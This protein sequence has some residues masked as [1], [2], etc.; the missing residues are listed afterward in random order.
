MSRL[1]WLNNYLYFCREITMKLAIHILLAYLVLTLLFTGALVAAFAIP[2]AAVKDNLQQSVQQVTDDG[3]MF[4]AQVGPVEPFKVGTFSDCLIL[5]IAYCSD[6]DHPLHAAMSDRFLILDGSPE[7]AALQMVEHPE[8]PLLQPVIYSR[9]WHGNQIIIKPL[10]YLTTMHG[11]RAINCVLLAVLLLLLLAVMWRRVGHADALIVTLCLA[12][13]IVPSVPMSLNYVPTFYIALLASLAILCRKAVTANW[14]RAV[15]LFFVI[16]ALTTYF[17][18]L[19][20]PMVALAVPLTVYMLYKKPDNAWRTVIMLSLA[21][22]AGYALLWATKWVLSALITGHAAIEDAM[23]AVTQRTVGYDEQDY[24]MWCLKATTA[25]LTAVVLI[26]TTVIALFGKS[27]QTLRRNSWML[28]VAMASFVWTFVLL[29]HTWRHPHF[30]WRTYV[31]LAI[32]VMLFLWHTLD[33]K[34]PLALFNKTKITSKE[35]SL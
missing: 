1:D 35:P 18:L 29:E 21:W 9:Y 19:T 20:T 12:A 7:D 27:W 23:G 11:I 28:L 34:H 26:I 33:L 2:G 3:K 32:G 30:T 4:T 22:L 8:N 6:A 14:N 13:V 24:M 17:D 5:G 31:V 10:L 25:I 16:G 15:I